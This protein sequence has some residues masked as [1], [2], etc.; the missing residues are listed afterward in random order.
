MQDVTHFDDSRIVTVTQQIAEIES[1]NMLLENEIEQAE[2]QIR[3]K[4]RTMRANEKRMDKMRAK[5]QVFA[6]A[7]TRLKLL[8]M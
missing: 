3:K 7:A 1:D 8:E 6:E 2:D 5:R 4:R